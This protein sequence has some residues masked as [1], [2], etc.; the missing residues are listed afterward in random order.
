MS[1]TSGSDQADAGL[2]P[3][4]GAK[5]V[6]QPV[7]RVE[8]ARLLTGNGRYVDDLPHAHALHLAVLR[9]DQAHARILAINLDAAR[10]MPGVRGVYVWADIAGIIKPALAT[11]RMAGYQPTPI[12][13]LAN[14]VVHFVGEPV[15]AV[16]AESR[17]L[18]E[19]ACDVIE[20][21]YEQLPV[22]TDP[23]AACAPDAPLLH[24]SLISNVLV[25]RT[26]SRGEVDSV[27]ADAPLTVSGRFRFHR[28]AP[29][30]ME[31]RTYM[32]QYD[33][34]R[35]ALMFYTS[36]QVP[37]IVRDALA[38]LLDMPGNRLTV[39][40]PDVGG[41]FG[42]KTSLYQEEMLVCALARHVGKT[43]KW[44]GDRLEDLLSTSQAF[45]QRVVAELAF[46]EEGHVLGLRAEVISDVG[47]YSIYPW[48][49]GIEAVQVISFLPGPYRLPCYFG[50]VR[51]VTTPK[52]PTGPY[53]G[54]GRPTSTF[55]MERLMDM[56]AVKLGIDPVEM[57][58][59]NLVQPHEFPYKTAVGIVWDQSAFIM[60]LEE[61]TREFGYER[62]REEQA[63]AR[64]AG[65]WVGIGV[66]SYAELS[67]IGSRISASPGMPINTGTDRCAIQLDSTGSITASFGCASHG[68]GH[69]TTLAQVL[70]DELGARFEDIRVITGNSATVPH[71]TG[72]YAS[73][74]AVISGGAAILAARE[75]RQ[76]MLKVSAA[77]LDAAPEDLEI[78][79]GVIH[80]RLGDASLTFK[81]L[82]RALYS[83]MGR[84]PVEAREELCVIRMYDPVTGTTSSST[85]MVQVEID[86]ETY[87]VHI[88]RYVIAED[89]GRV[90]NPMIVTGQTRGA[91][92]QGIGA[93]LL[94]EV[95]YDADGQLLT[96]SLVDYLLPS[97]PEVPS[98]ELVH[99]PTVAPNTLGGFRGMGEG[100][101]IGAPAAIANAVSDA[102]SHLGIGIAELPITPER[103]FRLVHSNSSATST[104]E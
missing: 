95:V 28:K 67:G 10:A 35:D 62:A 94:E 12:H 25:E 6:G 44:T 93:A 88:Q 29:M 72:S 20:V 8:D 70:A 17:Y 66:A 36:S 77:L 89:C 71:G 27:F 4:V 30:A 98:I 32:A 23:E 83:Q 38:E 14:G 31:P 69:E 56:A 46:D 78:S 18:A 87:A 73:R 82:A 102:L 15:V 63:K 76:R 68:Q 104:K 101:T 61:A 49:A 90:I 43:V 57:R 65:R 58:R 99:L 3:G 19:D 16:L 40:A 86:P 33:A 92:A 59:R 103:I 2:R 96:A 24:P 54:V 64:A 7:R 85:H 42:G 34:G 53:R 39:V 79:D 47:A 48:T 45:D 22:C 91:V 52:S 97:A 100:G 84:L 1:R 9:S 26:F 80:A 50:H 81:E 75:L 21:E 74:T 55:V 41:G 60:G 37:G 51:G 11:S 13:A 5:H